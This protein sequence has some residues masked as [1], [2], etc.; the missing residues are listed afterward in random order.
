MS[1]AAT[2]PTGAHQQATQPAARPLTPKAIAATQRISPGSGD[3][4]ALPSV[5]QML[6]STNGDVTAAVYDDVTGYTSVYRPDVAEDTA[7]IMKVDILATLLAQSQTEGV[8]LTAQEQELSQEMIEESNND[9]AQDLWDA[10]GGAAAVTSF[11]AEAGLTQTIPDGPG[12]WGLSTTTAADQ[13]R[14]LQKVAYSNSVLTQASRDY[15]LQ[16]MSNVDPGQA[17][18]VSAG[19]AP[20]AEVAIKDGWL[21]LAGG[22][23]QVNSDGYVNGDGR[24]YVISVLTDG[25]PTEADG[26]S[27]IQEIS[28]LVWQVLAPPAT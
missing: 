8:A 9:D 20:G 3:L 15:A 10:V 6:A 27:T 18:G 2:A 16:L 28:G 1:R 25:N 12:Y 22:G 13:V 23:W 11:D 7:S 21:P 17:W 24:N 19:V 14:L 5:A 4:F 26:I